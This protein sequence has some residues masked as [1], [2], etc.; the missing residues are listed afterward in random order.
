[1]YCPKLKYRLVVF[2]QP[3]FFFENIFEKITAFSMQP[4]CLCPITKDFTIN[5]CI[6]GGLCSV[7]SRVVKYLCQNHVQVSDYR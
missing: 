6:N 2:S 3:S 4:T 1:M 7:M 5:I